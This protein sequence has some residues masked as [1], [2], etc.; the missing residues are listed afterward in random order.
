MLAKHRK[1]ITDR[2]RAS[3][4]SSW[5]AATTTVCSHIR[6]VLLFRYAKKHD[7]RFEKKVYVKNRSAK[8]GSMTFD[9]CRAM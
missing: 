9:R 4:Y 3:P 2:N 1:N 7:K 8:T 5:P 6:F